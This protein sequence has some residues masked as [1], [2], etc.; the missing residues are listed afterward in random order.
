MLN[1]DDVAADQTPDGEALNLDHIAHWVPDN[2]AAG[3]ALNGL[4]FSVT[5]YSVQ[6]NRS[7]PDAAPTPAGAGNRCVMLE[8]GYL[9][10]LSP[11]HPTEVGREIQAG[12]DRYVGVH[13][14]AFGTRDAQRVHQRLN[15]A[16]LAQRPLVNLSRRIENDAGIEETARFTVARALPE[17]MPE[18]RVQCLTHHTPRL[19]WQ[20]R[21]LAHSNG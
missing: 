19:L 4:G 17:T 14:L 9:E 5:P 8:R 2:D 12:I 20:T 15:D 16:G 13:L 1:Q 10:F 21:Y 3:R 7:A 11:T 6:T 18:G